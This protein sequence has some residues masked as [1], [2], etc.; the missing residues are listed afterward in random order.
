[1]IATATKTRSSPL[2]PWRAPPGFLIGLNRDLS[3]DLATV[4]WSVPSTRPRGPSRAYLAKA[5]ATAS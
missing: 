4:E 2:A 1:M 5:A 3:V